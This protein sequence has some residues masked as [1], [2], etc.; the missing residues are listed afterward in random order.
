MFKSTSCLRVE[1][2]S[3]GLDIFFLRDGLEF[4]HSSWDLGLDGAQGASMYPLV[5][6]N[7]AI[8]DDNL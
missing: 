7:I 8:E 6:T 5:M 3:H 4:S 2:K 1:V